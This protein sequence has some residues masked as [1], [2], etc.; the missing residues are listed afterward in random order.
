[1]TTTQ[2]DVGSS[3]LDRF[4][5]VL[6]GTLVGF[7]DD[8]S[9]PLVFYAG[10]PGPGALAASS[11]VDLRGAHVGKPV[12]LMFESGDPRRPMIMGLLRTPQ[13]WP[14][15]SRPDTVEVDADG[16]QVVVT[17]KEQLVLRCGKASI[18]LTKPGKVLV[19]GVYVS[20]RASGVLRLKGGSVQIN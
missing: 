5:G 1:M 19:H 11:V 15:D 6:T 2:L 10:Q 7:K 20:N 17:A 9:I 3:A 4:Y 18:T 8:G 16:Q 12:A 14:S 13:A